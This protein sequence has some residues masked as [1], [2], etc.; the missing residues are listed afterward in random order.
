MP[1]ISAP[2]VVEHHA[3]TRA[4]LLTAA[5]D[6]LVADGAQAVTPASVG[7]RAGLA[8]SSVYQYFS[9]TGEILA[10]VV[11]AAFP[12]ATARLNSAVADAG[13]PSDAVDAYVVTALELAREG[14][15]AAVRAL[16]NV[17]LPDECQTRLTELH[18]EQARPLLDS[19]KTLGVADPELLGQLIGGVLGAGMAAIDGGTDFAR[20]ESSV[21]SAV[22]ALCKL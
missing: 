21:L 15:H 22:H 9:S 12:P 7:A 8:R 20:V 10:A 3:R 17:R 4:T 13:S 19:L 5:T 6:I 16:S 2:T 11:E 18:I 14:S 1:K